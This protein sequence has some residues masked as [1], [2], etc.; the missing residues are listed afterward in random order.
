MSH[1]SDLGLKLTHLPFSQRPRGLH[2]AK[3]PE[4]LRRLVVNAIGSAI[5]RLI[6]VAGVGDHP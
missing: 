6:I 4:C 5:S 2:D 1:R 3:L